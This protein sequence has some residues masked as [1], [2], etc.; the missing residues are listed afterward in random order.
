MGKKRQPC[1]SSATSMSEMEEKK[2]EYSASKTR[3][4]LP[5]P[6]STICWDAQWK[7]RDSGDFDGPSY[8]LT[9]PT[10]MAV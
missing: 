6:S 10:P 4:S 2:G 8:S 3:T 1:P 5:D 9:S 7:N